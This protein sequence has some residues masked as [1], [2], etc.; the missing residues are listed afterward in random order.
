MSKYDQVEYT[1]KSFVN[2]GSVYFEYPVYLI[3]HELFEG[4][5][6]FMHDILFIRPDTWVVKCKDWMSVSVL[7]CDLV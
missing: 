6:S 1:N 2:L 7:F 3:S 5:T 4:R